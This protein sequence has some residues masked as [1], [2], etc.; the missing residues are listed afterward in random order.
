MSIARQYQ[1][2][3]N[4]KAGAEQYRELDL[5]Q[6]DPMRM[7]IRGRGI[8]AVFPGVHLLIDTVAGEDGDQN[9][10]AGNEP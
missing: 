10:E 3:P 5:Q 9:N 4:C 1:I 6:A 7:K 8:E 2:D